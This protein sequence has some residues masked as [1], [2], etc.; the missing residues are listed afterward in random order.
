MMQWQF[1]TAAPDA[2]MVSFAQQI[3]LQI[4]QKVQQLAARL[5][6]EVAGVFE[7]VPSYQTL[8]VYYDILQLNERQLR[9]LLEPIVNEVLSSDTEA[10]DEKAQL[11]T[12]DVCYDPE[13]AAD[14]KAAAQFLNSS[15]DEVAA[16][17][18]ATTYHVYALG[19]APGFA[20]LG[21]VPQALRM[22]RHDS[23][24]EKVPKGSVAI[25]G[26]QT[27]IYPRTSPGGWQIIGR[28]VH[29]PRLQ[30]GDKVKFQSISRADYDRQLA[31][32]SEPGHD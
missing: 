14:L 5:R 9:H 26:Q 13:L 31:R 3:Q 16:L 10:Q 23:P 19:F 15:V 27:A 17:H 1:Q 30:A 29:W 28:A 24:R 6:H 7:V 21:D 8:L 22:P 32:Q 12:I 18:S 20:Y 11:H 25:A 4:N 2:L